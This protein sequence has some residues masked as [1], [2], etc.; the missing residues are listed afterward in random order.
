MK[1]WQLQKAKAKFSE[2][3]KDAAKEPQEVTVH[4]KSAAVVLSRQEYDR[5]SRPGVSFV[6][7]MR[8]SPLREVALDVGRDQTMTREIDL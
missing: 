4:G 5:L 1:S 2:V 6:E 3:V 8:S 7:F